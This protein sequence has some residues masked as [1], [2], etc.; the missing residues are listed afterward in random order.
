MVVKA[1]VIDE[2]AREEKRPRMESKGIN[3]LRYWRE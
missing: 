2:I 1:T 3:M